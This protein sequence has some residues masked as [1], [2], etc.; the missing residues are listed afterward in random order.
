MAD[1]EVFCCNLSLCNAPS[2][3]HSET[4]LNS[5]KTLR[6]PKSSNFLTTDKTINV[7]KK[8]DKDYPSS[9]IILPVTQNVSNYPKPQEKNEE[10]SIV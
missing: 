3:C 2:L 10:Y 1:E 7:P 5:K 6:H 4:D 8:N 9:Y